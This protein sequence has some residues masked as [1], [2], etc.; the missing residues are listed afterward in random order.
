MY[1][2]GK[3]L[4]VAGIV[5]TIAGLIMYFTGNRLSWLGRLPGDIRIEKENY[6]LYFPITTTILVSLLLTGII[7]V[8]RKIF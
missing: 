7:W 4:I 5:L 1:T 6:A 3:I 2:I 8:I